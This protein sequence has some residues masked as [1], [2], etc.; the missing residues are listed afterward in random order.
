MPKPTQSSL[1][2]ADFTG[3]SPANCSARFRANAKT[4]FVRTATLVNRLKSTNLLNGA[5]AF[6]I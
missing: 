2:K 1:N 3:V 4:C 5:D 6:S